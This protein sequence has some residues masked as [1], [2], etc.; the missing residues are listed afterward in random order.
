MQIKHRTPR[1]DMQYDSIIRK[2]AEIL[3]EMIE[4]EGVASNIADRHLTRFA[5]LSCRIDANGDKLDFEFA[6]FTD[7]PAVIKD[8]FLA[9]LD[10]ECVEWID[11]ARRAIFESDKPSDP[12][13]APAPPAS[14]EKK[15]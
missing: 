9:Y 13:T 11:Q 14:R 8:K 1:T 6:A 2:M 10:S 4:R 3:D 15:R 5:E 7:E 12:V